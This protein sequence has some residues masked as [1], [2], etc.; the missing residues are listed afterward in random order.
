MNLQLT[1]IEQDMLLDLI[2]AHTSI[3]GNAN[4]K[5]TVWVDL[6][7]KISKME[8]SVI[9]HGC[10]IDD[11]VVTPCCGVNPFNLDRGHQMT[12]NTDSITCP[13]FEGEKE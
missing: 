2:F 11:D 5:K 8:T 12:L 7:R 10:P 3:L 1:T 13:F 6:Y 9:V 4:E